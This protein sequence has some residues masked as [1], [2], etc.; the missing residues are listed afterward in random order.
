MYAREG[1]V[2]L[3]CLWRDF[4]SK[5]LRLCKMRALAG[6]EANRHSTDFAFGTALDL[7]E[8]AFLHTFDAFRLSLVP[9]QGEVIVVESVFPLSA[10]KL[11]SKLSVFES[12][13]V[14]MFPDEAGLN[15]EWLKQMGSTAFKVAETG[16]LWPD[17]AGRDTGIELENL[18]FADVFNTLPILFERPAFVIAHERPPWSDVVLQEPYVR[19]LWRETRGSSICLSD[20]SVREWRKSLSAKVI[21]LMLREFLPTI[22][23]G[24]DL[25]NSPSTGRPG[26]LDAVKRAYHELE[27]TKKN[28]SRKVEL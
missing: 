3:S 24:P 21:D 17:K 25:K 20:S 11:L 13:H 4:K 1:V 6:M 9:H 15:G 7:C 26:K 2:P 14:C 22:A 27:L 18:L 8:D 16:W 5:Y 19:N 10:A 12:T 28:F 23:R